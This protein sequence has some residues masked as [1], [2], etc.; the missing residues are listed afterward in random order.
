MQ[1][2]LSYR[3]I[4]AVGQPPE[5]ELVEVVEMFYT[6][7]GRDAFIKS[8]ALLDGN[9]E[10]WEGVEGVLRLVQPR[11]VGKNRHRRDSV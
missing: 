3:E 10:I 6:K 1:Y 8:H 4:G 9:Y 2:F 5:P 7:A 11:P